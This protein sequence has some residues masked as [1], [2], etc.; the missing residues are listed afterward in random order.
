M[1]ISQPFGSFTHKL[2]S[3][4]SATPAIR[5]RRAVV[6]GA[7]STWEL[8]CMVGVTLAAYLF[9]KVHQQGSWLLAANWLDNGAYIAV[10]KAI[11]AGHWAAPADGPTP[12]FGFPLLIAAVTQ[13]TAVNEWVAVIAISL[14]SVGIA[15][16]CLYRLYGPAAVLSLLI[17][18]WDWVGIGVLGGSEAPFCAGLFVA[19]LCARSGRWRAAAAIAAVA[20]TIRPVGV[21]ALAA[22]FVARLR[23]RDWQTCAE[24]TF[25]GLTIAFLYLAFVRSLT[26][27]PWI[28]FHTYRGDW[29]TGWPIGPPFIALIHS[30][31]PLI[32]RFG[33]WSGT[34]VVVIVAVTAA[35]GIHIASRILR[36]RWPLPEAES[37]FAVL[38][39]GF[40]LCYPYR[41]MAYEWPR[42]L[43]PAIPIL[44][45]AH[46][47]I[48]PGSRGFWWLV[49][50]ANAAVLGTAWMRI[51]TP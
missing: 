35:A 31:V 22:L 1:E 36:G 28:N 17:L 33:W 11:T 7:P 24:M 47:S 32:R 15:C 30:A 23:R 29:N 5:S 10:S 51:A 39:V 44:T 27:D 43:I 49:V 20:T 12:F 37:M 42:F 48:V 13:T 41:N 9:S 16:A 25:L 6:T 19:F 8:A 26:G 34:R 45:A 3:G 21:F 50:L 2:G 38:V 4:V 14:L 40:L 18:S 46:G